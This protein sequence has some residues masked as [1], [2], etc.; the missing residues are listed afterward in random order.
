[1]NCL[2]RNWAYRIE[3]VELLRIRSAFFLIEAFDTD[4]FRKNWELLKVFGIDGVPKWLI[5]LAECVFVI[6]RKMLGEQCCLGFSSPPLRRH[7]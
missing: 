1:M 4:S 6:K 3:F 5:A 2:I 7:L